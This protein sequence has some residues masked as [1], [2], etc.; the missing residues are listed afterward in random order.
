LRH[1]PSKVKSHS[2]AG[3]E[4]N[5]HCGIVVSGWIWNLPIDLLHIE[6]PVRGGGYIDTA[7]SGICRKHRRGR[8]TQ[9]PVNS[10]VLRQCEQ[11]YSMGGI[12]RAEVSE[13]STLGGRSQQPVESF[14][15]ARL[16]G[17]GK[18]TKEE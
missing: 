15:Y 2:L 14:C 4:V 9:C 11:V 17:F 1:V 8:R 7:Q 3:R 12:V 10:L 18:S 16:P 13:G 5:P 6:I